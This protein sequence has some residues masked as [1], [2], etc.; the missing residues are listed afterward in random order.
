MKKLR[1]HHYLIAFVFIITLAIN[2]LQSR[3]VLYT[4]GASAEGLIRAGIASQLFGDDSRDYHALI[5]SVV[6]PP[7]PALG[8]LLFIFAESW[9]D[10]A[11]FY[12]LLSLTGALG[13]CFFGMFTRAIGLSSIFGIVIGVAFFLNPW[14]PFAAW[15]GHSITG[16]L[17]FLAALAYYF[18]IWFQEERQRALASAAVLMAIACVWDLRFLPLA[19]PASAAVIALAG[20]QSE[21]SAPWRRQGLF[22]VFI[23]PVVYFPLLWVLFNWFIFGDILY[24]FH[25]TPEVYWTRYIALLIG[26]AVLVIPAYLCMR[27]PALAAKCLLAPLILLVAGMAYVTWQ[28]ATRQEKAFL[29]Q[30]I[31]SQARQQELEA[32]ERY[33]LQTKGGRYILV[34]GRPGYQLAARLPIEN[35]LVHRLELS[36]IDSILED[37]TGRDLCAVLSNA[38]VQEWKKIIGEERWD[39]RFLEDLQY[40]LYIANAMQ[41]GLDI[42]EPAWRVFYAIR[43]IRFD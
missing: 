5:D 22:L 37:T 24:L 41:A 28:P 12:I 16:S 39:A 14:L 23:T 35:G 29:G 26:M 1:F 19:L 25:S 32:L 3:Y 31:T 38:Q 4:Q 8:S 43:P 40:Q 27:R 36:Q 17:C 13:V 9:S 15:K 18:A 20:R 10:G 11:S 2:L 33:L 42:D 30:D 21:K 7:L 6:M 34:I